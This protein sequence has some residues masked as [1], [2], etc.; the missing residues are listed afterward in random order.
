MEML[1]RPVSSGTCVRTTI[2]DETTIKT[3]TLYMRPI[4]SG[5]TDNSNIDHEIQFWVDKFG[6]ETTDITGTTDQ[7]SRKHHHKGAEDDDSD[8]VSDDETI[9]FYSNGTVGYGGE[10][11]V[12]AH[13]WKQH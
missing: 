1:A 2:M 9:Y 8:D 3:E 10:Q 13:K 5:A 6:L 4:F 11:T 12:A 7:Q